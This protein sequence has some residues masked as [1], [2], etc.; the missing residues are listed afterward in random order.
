MVS[1]AENTAQP[2]V[3]TC[4]PRRSPSFAGCP[5]D[6][7]AMRSPERI[8]E[9]IALAHELRTP[10]HLFRAD[11]FDKRIGFEPPSRRRSR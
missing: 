8:A 6:D 9:D 1:T 11:D 5:V 10:P 7:P 2:A 4:D 3:C